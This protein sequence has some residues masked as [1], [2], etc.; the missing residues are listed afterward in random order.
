MREED[1]STFPATEE[2]IEHFSTES[3]DQGVTNGV[4]SQLKEGSDD[5]RK[6]T[7]A[8]SQILLHRLYIFLSRF[9]HCY[10]WKDAQCRDL[11]RWVSVPHVVLSVPQQKPLHL[12]LHHMGLLDSWPGS[13]MFI[14]VF[15]CEIHLDSLCCLA[16]E[17]EEETSWLQG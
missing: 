14:T 6:R 4:T 17:E 3:F 16:E 9:V 2:S 8:S 10:L 12:I 13:Y 15:N 1:S 5:G 7:K 11:S